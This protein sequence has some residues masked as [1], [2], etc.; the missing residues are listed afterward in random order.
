MAVARK[1][2][3]KRSARTDARLSVHLAGISGSQVAREGLL[4]EAREPV[5]GSV[6]HHLVALQERQRS[7]RCAAPCTVHKR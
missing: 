2:D 1:A 6:C 4:L 5:L 7:D 3:V